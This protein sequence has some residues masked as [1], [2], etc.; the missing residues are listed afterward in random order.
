MT[1]GKWCRYSSSGTALNCN[2]DPVTDT[3]TTYTASGSLLQLSGTAFSLKEG[4][5]TNGKFCTYSSTTGLVCT[6]DANNY[7][8]PTAT[9]SVLGGVKVGTGLSITDGVLSA[10]GGGYTNLTSFVDQTAWRLFYSDGSGD[11]KDLA[12]G[13]D[14]E[15]LKSNGATSVPSWGTPTGG[16]HDA[17]TLAGQ[18]YLSLST[19]QITANLI[20][21]SNINWDTIE[22]IASANINWS[23]IETISPIT[24]AMIGDLGAYLTGNQ[25]IT[26]SGDVTGSGATTITASINWSNIIDLIGDTQINWTSVQGITGSNIN[27]ALI[28]EDVI[29]GVN[30]AD[31]GPG[32]RQ[33]CFIID[34]GGSA[35]TTGAKAWVRAPNAFTIGGMEITAD[36]SGSCVV[37]IWKDTYAN[38]PPTVADTITASAKPTLST[39]QK[40]QDT[41]LT[42]WT[43][44]INAGDYLRANVDSC[45]TITMLEV[46]LYE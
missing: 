8:L 39:A 13:S 1:D 26:L 45:S 31:Y 3:N 12:L 10:T 41:T 15:F 7:T 33:I 29:T 24:E 32:K 20:K 38:F 25:T 21:G 6:S 40:A 27:W 5:L 23:N 16:A 46:C 17:V 36:Q 35:G 37:D 14:G 42:G 9:D 30:W 11:V 2:V 34:G 22:N 44:T 19:Q 28:D 4:T 18:D 43:K